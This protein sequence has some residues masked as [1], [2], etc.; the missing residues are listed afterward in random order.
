MNSNL[1]SNQTKILPK[2]SVLDLSPYGAPDEGR[3][4]AIRLDFNENTRAVC[5]AYPE[6][7]PETWISAYPEYGILLDKLSRYMD[8]SPD[9]ITLT[10]G[11]DEAIN[12]VANTFVEP[13]VHRAVIS[14]PC[15]IMIKQCL[16]IAGA[17]LEEVPVLSNL[18]F[19]LESIEAALGQNPRM[20]MFAT[21]DNPT[22]S[23]IPTATIEKWCQKYPETLFVIDEAYGEFAGTS[24][25][26]LVASN[27]N[28]LV[29]KTFSKA[30]AMAGLRLG[31]IIGCPELLQYVQRVRLPYSVNS[32][33]V[34][35]ATRLVDREDV[36][37]SRVA[38]LLSERSQL[39]TTLSENGYSV[40]ETKANW[41]LLGAGML[42]EQFT[43][44]CKTKNILVRNRSNSMFG[45]FE[46]LPAPMWG[47]VRVSV[48]GREE[49]S[50]FES[51]LT[52]FRNNFAFIF[53]LDGTLVDTSKSFDETVRYLVSKFSD[54]P[55]SD[56]ELQ[57]LRR[58]G[59]FNDDWVA[60]RE[61]LKRRGIELELSK[62]AFE[63]E[64]YYLKIAREKEELLIE[65]STLEAIGKRNR[66]SIVTGRTR[67][68]YNP[69]WAESFDRIFEKIYCVDDISGY[70]SKPS[71]DYLNRALEDS[72]CA[73][74][75]YVGNSVDDMK[76]AKSAGLLA[77]GIAIGADDREALKAA[78]A[79]VVLDSCR[80]LA[81]LL[82]LPDE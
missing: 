1:V 2:K 14:N 37:V 61:L 53:D 34:F 48:G 15:F 77:L 66:I 24:V 56:G 22:G 19:D 78:G 58:E 40:R 12:L 80:Q 3:L 33:A 69:V 26:P 62:I 18:E 73:S 47:W 72:G 35:T 36:M 44:F 82:M 74:G 5:G 54:V 55:L 11:S 7:M 38:E 71:P 81:D 29:L 67:A 43:N 59:G 70:H 64:Q 57:K 76:A 60:S 45:K 75:A 50:A 16:K 32:A 30:W 23:V 52:E 13:G 8:V 31:M 46:D 10:N 28:L 25:I 39:A 4:N 68:E 27:G 65:A 79:D 42:A 49:M 51:A 20:A 9:S 21:P 17:S 41:C 6:G 63:G